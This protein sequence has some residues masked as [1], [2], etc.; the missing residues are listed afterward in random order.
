MA[1]DT[2]NR[3]DN[4]LGLVFGQARVKAQRTLTLDKQAYIV[5]NP[6]GLVFYRGRVEEQSG[7][8][9]TNDVSRC[10]CRLLFGEYPLR[11]EHRL[12]FLRPTLRGC[13]C[14]DAL[15]RVKPLRLLTLPCQKTN[16]D[17]VI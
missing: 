9:A 16:P 8:P 12:F 14:E 6:L 7:N 1:P 4:P 11:S 2:T 5:C 17:G 3:N 13:R 15:G 10:S